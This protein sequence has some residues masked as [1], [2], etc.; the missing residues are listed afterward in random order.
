[1]FGV[2]GEGGVPLRIAG[3]EDGNRVYPSRRLAG[4]E[5][6]VSISRVLRYTSGGR[7]VIRVGSL[8]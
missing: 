5:R 4:G 3:K 1:M 2:W 7:M 6:V 8:D